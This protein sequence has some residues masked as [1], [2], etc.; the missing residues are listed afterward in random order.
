MATVS[1]SSSSPLDYVSGSLCLIGVLC[2][3]SKYSWEI[4][5]LYRHNVIVY[6]V[7]IILVLFKC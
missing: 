6:Y 3:H 4:A 5:R 2:K 1:V 7:N